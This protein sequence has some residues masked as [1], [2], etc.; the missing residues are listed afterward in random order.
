MRNNAV[1]YRRANSVGGKIVAVFLAGTLPVWIE[2]IQTFNALPNS[3]VLRGVTNL[4]QAEVFL[5]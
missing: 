1:Q 4:G 3:N 2:I 5:Q